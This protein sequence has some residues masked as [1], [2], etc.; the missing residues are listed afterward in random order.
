M[1]TR[2]PY[3]TMASR[4]PQLPTWQSGPH[5]TTQTPHDTMAPACHPATHL[6]ERPE[7]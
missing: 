4:A 3:D 1:T 7:Q 2:P 6:A 5:M